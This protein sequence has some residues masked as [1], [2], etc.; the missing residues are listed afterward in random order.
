M[1]NHIGNKEICVLFAT[2]YYLPPFR[3]RAL[4]IP[5]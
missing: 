1:E 3:R 4:E 2:E 5:D